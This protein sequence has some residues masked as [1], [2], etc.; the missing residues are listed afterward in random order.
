IKS[1]GILFLLVGLLTLWTEL[2]AV[3]EVFILWLFSVAMKAGTCPPDYAMCYRRET[4]ECAMDYDCKEQKKCCVCHCA[5]RCVEPAEE[6]PG[7]CP[8]IT[9]VCPMVDPPNRCE[10]DSKCPENKKCCDTGCGK[11]CVWLVKAPSPL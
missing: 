3:T 6:T 9:V 5:M 8:A 11:D 2:P 7:T 4:D 10:K 1:V